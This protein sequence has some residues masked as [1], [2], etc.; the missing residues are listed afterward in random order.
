MIQVN[1]HILTRRSLMIFIKFA[2]DKFALGSKFVLGRSVNANCI[3]RL[4]C[5]KSKKG[6]NVEAIFD[7]GKRHSNCRRA[8]YEIFASLVVTV[9]NCIFYKFSHALMQSLLLLSKIVVQ[10]FLRYEQPPL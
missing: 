4:M 1:Q 8:G 9:N 2:F 3:N 5:G 7:N 10:T 6:F